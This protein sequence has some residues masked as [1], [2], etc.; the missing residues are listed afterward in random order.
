MTTAPIAGNQYFSQVFDQAGHL[1]L[2]N[3][4]NLRI[5][6]ATTNYLE[7]V[8]INPNLGEFYSG[9]TPAFG[10]QTLK[11][12]S[13]IKLKLDNF[14]HVLTSQKVPPVCINAFKETTAGVITV[15]NG[16]QVLN[17]STDTAG[18]V[19]LAFV[20]SSGVAGDVYNFLFEFNREFPTGN[21]SVQL[22]AADEGAAR[23]VSGNNPAGSS[24]RGVW[25]ETK[26]TTF[27]I[28][29]EVDAGFE[30]DT[31]R[32]NYFVSDPVAFA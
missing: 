21:L 2:L 19:D 1:N 27:A 9:A 16:T 22:T 25:V 31:A 11:D 7:V 8:A 17:N 26:S 28:R 3:V 30:Q 32:F 14:G 5:G 6:T 23:L 10:S 4:S 18:Q 12:P 13:Q 29:F 20:A 15:M 24:S